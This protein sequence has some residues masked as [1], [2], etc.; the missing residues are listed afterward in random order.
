MGI[1]K[2]S[3]SNFLLNLFSSDFTLKNSR[4]VFND[5]VI[6]G[7][8]IDLFVK[9]SSEFTSTIYEKASYEEISGNSFLTLDIVVDY[10]LIN[11]KGIKS[12]ITNGKLKASITDSIYQLKFNGT[13][14]K[15][16]RVSIF[17]E[18]KLL[19]IKSVKL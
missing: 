13:N 15:G 14:N 17:Y 6:S 3:I 8:T 1:H 16:K 19:E 12:H 4:P 18:G 5:T 2:D 9:N 11:E 10:D 7:V